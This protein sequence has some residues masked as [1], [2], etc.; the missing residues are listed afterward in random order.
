MQKRI[1]H[2]ASVNDPHGQ[3]FTMKRE[4]VRE[5]NRLNRNLPLDDDDNYYECDYRDLNSDTPWQWLGSV[6]MDGSLDPC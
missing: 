2:V 5:M 6:E 1:Y 4:A 3:N